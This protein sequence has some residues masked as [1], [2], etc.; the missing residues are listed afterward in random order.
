MDDLPRSVAERMAVE[1]AALR[2]FLQGRKYHVALE[3]WDFAKD[4]HTGT[5][6]DGVT[7]EFYHQIGMAN[8]ARTLEAGLR[9]PEETFATIFLH[10]C[11]ED[12]N[13]APR[14]LND[15]FGILIGNSTNALSKVVQGRKRSPE[16]VRRMIEEDPI[17]SVV[18]GVD[19][20]NNQGSML[21]VFSLEK[22]QEYIAE[23]KDFIL[24]ILKTARRRFP[25]QEPVYENIKHLLTREIRLFEEMHSEILKRPR[26]EEPA[27]SAPEFS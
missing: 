10:D 24:P 16:D 9:H 13:V 15:R 5:R 17:A 18:K 1:T 20:A 4:H 21:G 22:Q 23:T 25:D 14:L 11:V 12:G 8:F 2:Y 6:K 26:P 27:Y 19:R 3:A 7:P